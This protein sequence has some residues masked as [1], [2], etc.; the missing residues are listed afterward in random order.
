MT[1]ASESEASGDAKRRSKSRSKNRS[2]SRSL[3]RELDEQGTDEN[4][5]V[6][7]RIPEAD[8]ES[9]TSPVKSDPLLG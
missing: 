3:S 1:S 8:K 9:E 6:L 4:E 5:G 2:V 7:A